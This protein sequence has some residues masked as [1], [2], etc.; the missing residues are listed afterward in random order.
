MC[1]H[2]PR[3]LRQKICNNT[4]RESKMAFRTAAAAATTIILLLYSLG[5]ANGE[6][7]LVFL[8]GDNGCAI[9]SLILLCFMLDN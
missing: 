5:S 8:N 2:K 3:A 6:K 4:A 1:E 7:A 9:C